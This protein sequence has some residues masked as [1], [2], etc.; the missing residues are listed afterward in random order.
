MDCGVDFTISRSLLKLTSIVSV[1]PSNHRIL[2]PL[3][4]PPPL[5][6]HESG[7]KTHFEVRGLATYSFFLCF[8]A[9]A[10]SEAE[11]NPF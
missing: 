3:Q 4:L 8:W 7:L 10:A 2:C 5:P 9:L 1:M 11:E 6:V